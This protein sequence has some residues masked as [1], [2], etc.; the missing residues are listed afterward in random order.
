MKLFPIALESRKTGRWCTAAV[1][2]EPI[3][4]ISA[5]VSA[6]IEADRV[7][8]LTFAPDV[9]TGMSALLSI[10]QEMKRMRATMMIVQISEIIASQIRPIYV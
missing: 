7:L 2:L 5:E 8:S 3:A 1:W 9:E 6:L 10:A 4:V